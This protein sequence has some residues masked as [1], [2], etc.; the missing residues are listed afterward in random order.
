MLIP[1]MASTMSKALVDCVSS[2]PLLF[3]LFPEAYSL[4]LDVHF[5]YPVKA[6][7]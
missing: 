7:T 3:H 2:V 6:G 1:N 5:N 4:I